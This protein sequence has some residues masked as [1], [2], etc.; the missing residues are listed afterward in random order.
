M[1]WELLGVSSLVISDVKPVRYVEGPENQG[2]ENIVQL[3]EWDSEISLGLY[4]R[5]A[6]LS[7]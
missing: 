2:R 5:A 1:G 7:C 4:R 6:G 3:G